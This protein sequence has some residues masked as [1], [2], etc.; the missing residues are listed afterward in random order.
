M[1]APKRPNTAQA[2]RKATEKRVRQGEETMAAKLREAG[3]TVTPPEDSQEDSMS[4]IGIVA[5]ESGDPFKVDTYRPA[6]FLGTFQTLSS[7]YWP[8][9][10]KPRRIEID[11]EVVYEDRESERL[12]QTGDGRWVVTNGKGPGRLLTEAEA[13]QWF[14]DNEYTAEDRETYVRS[15]HLN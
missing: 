10:G 12:W 4:K 1:P 3:W 13:E 2:T 5:R 15:G 8:G 6:E 9:D 7:Q 14:T 11:G